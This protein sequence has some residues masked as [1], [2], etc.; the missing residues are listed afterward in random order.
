[1]P[2]ETLVE[3]GAFSEPVARAMAEGMHRLSGADYAL[4]T[5]GVA[6]PG[7]GSEEKPVGLV[8]VGIADAGGARVERLDLSAW[9]R[10][11]AMIRERSASAA[12]DLLRR[13]ILGKR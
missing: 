4:S 6:G 8:Y 3:H 11:R 10:S 12:F 5:T 9:R 13:H 7:G 1:V 2:K